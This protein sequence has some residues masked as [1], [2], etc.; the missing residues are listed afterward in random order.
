MGLGILTL[1]CYSNRDEELNAEKKDT[2]TFLQ[3]PYKSKEMKE[4]LY[5]NFPSKNLL[6]HELHFKS[7]EC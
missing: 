3:Y 1:H 7:C 6:C 5:Q 4:I 2:N